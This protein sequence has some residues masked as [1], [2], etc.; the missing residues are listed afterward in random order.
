MNLEHIIE[1]Q[2]DLLGALRKF[3]A[4]ELDSAA[5]KPFGAP[6]GIYQQRN[7]KFMNRIRLTGGEIPA[8]TLRFLRGLVY[9][10]GAEFVHVST[11]QNIQLHGVTPLDSIE[12]VQSCTANGL[13]Y[14]GGG[15][16]TFRNISITAGS[17]IAPDGSCDL[18]PYARFLTDAIFDWDIA[19]KLPRKIKIGMASPS[20]KGLALRQ[21]LGF[22]AASDA[23]GNP[24]FAVYGAGGFGRESAAGI[25][26]FDFL[27]ARNLVMAARAMVEL[28]SDHG[29]RTNRGRARIRFIRKRLG[30]EAFLK[31]Y[32]EYYGRLDPADY[33]APPAVPHDWPLAGRRKTFDAVPEPDSEEYR[34]WRAAAVRPTR[35]GAD[36]ATVTLFVPRGVL[37]PDEFAAVADLIS[38]FGLPAVR[39]TFEQNIVLPVVSAAAL[40]HLYRALR[41]LPV[42]L[43]F[44]S[45]SGQL[46]C[47]IGATVCKI[48]VLDA[49][50]YGELAAAALDRYFEAHPEERAEKAVKLIELMHFSGC[51][52]SCTAHEVSCFGFQGCKKTLNGVLTDC[53]VLWRNPEFPASP[54]GTDT[55]EVIPAAEIG[56]RVIELLKEEKILNG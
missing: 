33:P 38:D 14:R 25:P 1:A 11:R 26:L 27:P 3:A 34:K 22:V 8:E 43:T 44:R 4:G 54:I 5:M 29:D 47:C 42:D 12:V 48:G 40:P 7:G 28:F 24:G 30:D 55:G 6:F 17:G 16:D 46:D 52:N 49:P 31:L 15:G 9:R 37:S 53:F 10:S 13:P 56:E 51:P 2:S 41:Q 45:F 18:A 35:F 19:F 32:R 36:T 50:K 20:D 23:D 21:D 39:L